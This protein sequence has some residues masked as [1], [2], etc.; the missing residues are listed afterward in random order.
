MGFR[1]VA[2]YHCPL[3]FVVYIDELFRGIESHPTCHLL[4]YADDAKVFSTNPTD[5]QC[6]INDLRR[7][8]LKR[9]LS[10]AP[11]K[12]EHLAVSRSHESVHKFFIDAQ[13]VSSVCQVK[14]LGVFISNDL[15]WASYISYNHN[16]AAS[17]AYQFC[18]LFLLIKC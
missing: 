16:A 9:Q 18:V 14:D 2:Y 17:C 5:L 3:L 6:A 11:S 10:L 12:C 7:C 4:L 8:L 1:K 15:K 13:E